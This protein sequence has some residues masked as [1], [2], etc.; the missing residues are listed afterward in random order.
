MN[1]ELRGAMNEAAHGDETRPRSAATL[2][3]LAVGAALF[4]VVF[5]ALGTWQVQRLYWKL[6]LIARVHNCRMV[7]ATKG[8]AYFRKTVIG[9]F[10]CQRHGYLAGARKVP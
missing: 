3:V 2:I 7:P 9:Q 8:F 6:D 1:P 5:M 4:F 10:A